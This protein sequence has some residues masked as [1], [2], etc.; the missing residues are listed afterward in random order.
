M[1]S[2]KIFVA[3][4]WSMI[5][6]LAEAQNTGNKNEIGLN[7]GALFYQG[8][9]TPDVIGSYKTAKPMIQLYYNR[10]LNPYFSLRAN[11]VVGA[12]EGDESKYEKPAYMRLRN[13][14]F[15]TPVTELSGLAVF[16]VFGNDNSAK[17]LKLSP[18]VFAGGGATFLNIKRDW[19][20]VDSSMLH[21][22]S[23]TLSGLGRDTTTALPSI[24]PVLPVGIGLG[25]Q[26][27]P[28]LSLVAEAN[29]R[30]VFTDHLDGFSYAANPARK[31]A[32]YSISLGAKFSFGN[33]KN[34]SKSRVDCPK[35]F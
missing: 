5:S 6:L 14:K 10:I 8:D 13:F 17:V 30:F 18:F 35:G 7:A 34:F 22:G 12:L 27:L 29:Y 11:L 16:N 26:I 24:I 20:R 3:V 9:L 2:K 25:Y 33:N 4:I 32:Y 1:L 15:H 23:T 21:N 31:D 28:N 19:S